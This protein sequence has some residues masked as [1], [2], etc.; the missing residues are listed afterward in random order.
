M[1]KLAADITHQHAK[2]IYKLCFLA[3]QS[4]PLFDQPHKIKPCMAQLLDL[5]TMQQFVQQECQYFVF[6]LP[7]KISEGTFMIAD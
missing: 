5:E 3:S 4:V 2:E 7:Q 1:V 6:L